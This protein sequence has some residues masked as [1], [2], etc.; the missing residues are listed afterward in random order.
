MPKAR[1]TRG[2]EGAR[3]ETGDAWELGQGR[4]RRR[5]S[6]QWRGDRAYLERTVFCPLFGWAKWLC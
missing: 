3:R 4:M 5:M 2:R 6:G 1:V